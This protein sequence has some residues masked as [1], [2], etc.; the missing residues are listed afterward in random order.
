MVSEEIACIILAVF[1]PR[2]LVD[3]FDLDIVGGSSPT[4]RLDE[5]CRKNWGFKKIQLRRCERNAQV[6]VVDG[7][8]HICTEENTFIAWICTSGRRK[9]IPEFV[10][11]RK[12]SFFILFSQNLF[13]FWDI[14]GGLRPVMSRGPLTPSMGT[15]FRSNYN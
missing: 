10:G 7:G 15:P 3:Y 13:N 8:N 9:H 4:L 14:Q 11:F 5:V 2:H 1:R 12:E 6:M